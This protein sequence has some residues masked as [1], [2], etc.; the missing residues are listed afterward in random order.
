MMDIKRLT[1]ILLVASIPNIFAARADEEGSG[2]PP[3]SADSE[4]GV[5]G[6]PEHDH[7]GLQVGDL[8]LL[9]GDT[10]VMAA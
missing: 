1:V 6:F 3:R 2:A 7:N 8:H 4:D 9:A 10:E 5:P